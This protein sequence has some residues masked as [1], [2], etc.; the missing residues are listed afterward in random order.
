M[1]REILESVNGKGITDIE[2]NINY[3]TL[4]FVGS[5]GVTYY[6]AMGEFSDW[7]IGDTEGNF[8]AQGLKFNDLNKELKKLGKKVS[9]KVLDWYQSQ[10]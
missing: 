1:L 9:K 7:D 5:D 10:M 3:D 8:V 2:Q 4:E 6:I